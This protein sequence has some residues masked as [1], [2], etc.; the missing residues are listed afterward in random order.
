[1]VIASDL[2]KGGGDPALNFIDRDS[3]FIY[4]VLSSTKFNNKTGVFA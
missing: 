1:M 3:N 4:N 2:S